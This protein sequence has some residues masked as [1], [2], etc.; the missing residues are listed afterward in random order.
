MVSSLH[1]PHKMLVSFRVLPRPPLIGL[2]VLLP[3]TLQAAPPPSSELGPR[4]NSGV[5]KKLFTELPPTTTGITFVNPIDLKHPLK[6][7]YTSALGGGGVAAGDFDSDGH[8]DLYFVSGARENRLYRNLGNARFADITAKAGVG[9]GEAWGAGVAAVDIE[10]DGDLDL[11]VCNYES[12]NQLFLNDGKGTFTESARAFGLD[13]A[14]AFGMAAFADYDLD[15]DLDLYLLAQRHYRAGGRPNK[16]VTVMKDGRMQMLPDYEDYYGLTWR[17]GKSELNN[18]GARDKL[19]RN[20]SS[21]GKPHFVDVTKSAGISDGRY[22]GNSVTWWD[23]NHDGLPDLYVGNDFE[24]PDLLYRNNGNGTFTDVARQQLPHTSWFTMGADC[25]DLNNDG[26][27]DFLVADMAGTT[28]YKSKTT[29]GIMGSSKW[30]MQNADPPQYMRNCLYVNSGAG[31]FLEAAFMA[32]LASSDWTWAVKFGDLDCDGRLD[33]FISNGMTRNFNDSD[34]PLKTDKLHGNTEW[35]LYED[36][37]TRPEKN[38]AYRNLGDLAFADV[39][40]N[41]GLG[42]VG[43]SYAAAWFDLEG[44]GDLDL[45]IANLDEPP[46]IHRNDSQGGSRVVIRL[47]GN[48]RNRL[49]IGASVKLRTAS[50]EQIRQFNPMRGFCS[51]NEPSIHFGLGEAKSIERLTV[52]WPGGKSVTYQDL[53]ANRRYTIPEEDAKTLPAAPAKQAAPMFAPSPAFRDARHWEMPFNDFN[54]QPLLPNRLSQSGPGLACGDIDGDG[55]EDLFLGG[56]AGYVG[57]LLTNDG[58]G[59]FLRSP[60]TAAERHKLSED[61]GALFFDSDGDRDLDLYVVSGGVEA[62]PGHHSLTDRLYLNDGTGVFSPAPFGTVP[63]NPESGSTVAAADYDRDG[64]LDLFVG[65]RVIPGAYPEAPRSRLLQN[66]GGSFTD[67]TFKSPDLLQPGLVTGALWSDANGDGWIDLLLSNEWGPVKFFRNEKGRL[68]NKTDEAGLGN[69]LGWWTGITGGDFDNDGDI[70]YLATNFGLNTKYQASEN[71]PEVLFYGDFEGT[72][73][74]RIIEAGFEHGVCY[75]HRGF[76]C[77]RNA[78]PFVGAKLKSFHNFAKSTLGDIYPDD[79]LSGALRLEAN[80]LATGILVNDGSAKFTFRPL[81]RLAQISPSFGSVVIDANGDGIHDLFLAQNFDGPQLETRPMRSGLGILL[82]GDGM[83]N[84]SPVWPRRSGL[85]VP[86][87]AKSVVAADLNMDG[88]PDLVI[89]VNDGPVLAFE[90]RGETAPIA[91]HLSGPKGNPTGVGA[92]VTMH[93]GDGLSRLAEVTAGNGYLSQA[94]AVLYFVPPKGSSAKRVSVRW[95]DGKTSTAP[96]V[97]G[98]RKVI[99]SYE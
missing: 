74:K 35:D 23:F 63:L 51:T 50:G 14:G 90:S 6:R 17:D 24:D 53:P 30:F 81:P 36:T 62:P 69:L 60:F 83:G 98:S 29:M 79:K 13:L 54:L 66:R 61:L 65:G 52:T 70:D 11:Y 95:P 12:P 73:R 78:M 77:S 19:L 97:S 38:R 99:V 41:W 48:G 59:R 25:G 16:Q 87:D 71:A 5:V 26:L 68:V 64:D 9:G 18:V 37:P 56:C 34:N 28:H 88:R 1:F 86:E 10:G 46:S 76:S 39:S 91:V 20:E 43:M 22:H 31:R 33:V 2:L 94:P 92:R 8:C 89:G 58:T 67:V 44:D 85:L 21:G 84:F 15:G 27:V 42:K 55:D 49:G 40:D 72:G 7:L 32:G 47:A 4:S 96:L 3:A 45:A 93:F 80:T 75:P 82:E 57:T